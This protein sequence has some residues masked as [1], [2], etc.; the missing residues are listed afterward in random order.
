MPLDQDFKMTFAGEAGDRVLAYLRSF[1]GDGE[2]VKDSERMNCYM[3][4]RFSVYK[5]II[6][7]IEMEK[8]NDP[9]TD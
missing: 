1:A 8:K 3:Q 2:I 4:G 7:F 5:E 6:K 9:K